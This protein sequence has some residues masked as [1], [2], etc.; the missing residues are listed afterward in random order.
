[1]SSRL[2]QIPRH[3]LH[4]GLDDLSQ[5][6][7]PT[8][9]RDALRAR[10]ADLPLVPDAGSSAQLIGP[11]A[12]TLPCLA[13]LARHVGQGFRD[14]NLAIAHDSARLTSERHKLIFLPGD[15]LAD[16]IA[17]GDKRPF[18]ETVVFVTGW[19]ARVNPL[20]SSRDASGLAT[21]V[22]AESPIPDLTHWRRVDLA[23]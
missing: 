17:Q 15:V 13:V 20:L 6:G 19:T 3:L 8:A 16:A 12:I 9:A 22:S 1:V 2:V 23:V 14:T 18:N 5:L 10:L 7:V 4:V 11:P 21:F